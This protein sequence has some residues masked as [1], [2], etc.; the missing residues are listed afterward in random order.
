MKLSRAFAV[1]T[2]MQSALRRA[3]DLF[4]DWPEP[5]TTPLRADCGQRAEWIAAD[6]A[7]ALTA[8]PASLL[9]ASAG[10]APRGYLLR[11]MRS[12]QSCLI[13]TPRSVLDD[14]ALHDFP[15]RGA[16]VVR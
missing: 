9:P 4:Y 6:V 1:A 11:G 10:S 2:R 7:R 13:P 5:L 8:F 12:R 15:D 14:Q 16:L 3:L